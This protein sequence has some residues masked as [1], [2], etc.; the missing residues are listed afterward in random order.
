[1]KTIAIKEIS[2]VLERIGAVNPIAVDAPGA[3]GTLA[4]HTGNRHHQRPEDT[5]GAPGRAEPV[6][7]A[8]TGLPTGF[9]DL[10]RVTTG[11]HRG[12]LVVVGARPSMGKTTFATHLVE[13][14]AMGARVPVVVFSPETPAE[15]LVMK[16]LA[17]RARIDQQRVRT[18]TLDP[19]ERSRLASQAALLGDT[20]IFIVDQRALTP[21]ELRAC[22][23]RL[24]K[25]HGLG[26]VVVD[27]LQ[28]MHVP[29]SQQT[30]AP[31]ARE[32]AR[33]TDIAEVSRSL[34]ALAS[35]MRV[36]VVACSQLDRGLEL[37]ANMRPVMSDLPERG[38][39]EHDADLIVFIYRDEVYHA[40]SKH[41]GK[42]ELIVAKQR[43]GPLGSVDLAFS[44][45]F[46]RFADVPA[47]TLVRG[48]AGPS[49]S[50]PPAPHP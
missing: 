18:G 28:L 17:S 31:R 35:E 15:H 23:R 8:I 33:R 46:A 26:L 21:S 11:L 40:Q 27:T 5:G 20:D 7:G 22:C 9:R 16:M 3:T 44:G 24:D 32:L 39:I 10:D 42:A 12:E 13:A 14:A 2:G 41:K 45:R 36:P 19:D 38:A 47:L 30:R 6:P 25:A 50:I 34:K 48:G 37:R 49:S 43:N 4:Q 29:G 1:M